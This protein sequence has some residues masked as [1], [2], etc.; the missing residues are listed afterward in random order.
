MQYQ[1]LSDDSARVSVADQSFHAISELEKATIEVLKDQLRIWQMQWFTLLRRSIALYAEVN[2]LQDLHF[3]S[4]RLSLAVKKRR[5][6]RYRLK[7]AI[8]EQEKKRVLYWIYRLDAILGRIRQI[9]DV[10]N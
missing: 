9:S 10:V 6:L 2:Q 5:R 3:D 8:L 1:L 4:S 7:S